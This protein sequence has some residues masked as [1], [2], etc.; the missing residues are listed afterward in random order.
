VRVAAR[1]AV[2]RVAA[3]MVETGMRIDDKID[4]PVQDRVWSGRGG[5]RAARSDRPR[6]GA[7]AIRAPRRPFVSCR[8]SGWSPASNK[9]RPLGCSIKKTGTGIVMSPSPPSI[10]RANSPVT[11]PQLNAK[12]WAD[13]TD[14]PPFRAGV[15]RPFVR[16]ERSN[17]VG[18][19]RFQDSIV[20]RLIFG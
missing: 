6:P 8:Q 11:V 20:I 17:V 2:A 12:S 19:S 16:L 9:A 3:A 14:L 10:R 13:V 4:L 7:E 15:A 1:V 18:F 5:Q